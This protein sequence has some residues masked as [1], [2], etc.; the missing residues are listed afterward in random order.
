MEE[1]GNQPDLIS[2]LSDSILI[3]ILSFLPSNSSGQTC[4]LSRRWRHLWEY[5]PEL[6]LYDCADAQLFS[7]LTHRK[8][9]KLKTFHVSMRRYWLSTQYTIDQA[10]CYCST[11]GVEELYL[12][13]CY[14]IDL[15]LRAKT[16][17]C[18]Q[19]SLRVLQLD[20]CFV[21]CPNRINL[22]KVV[23]LRLSSVCMKCGAFD[24][25]ITGC[26]FVESFEIS[27]CEQVSL[28]TFDLP[29]LK[30]LVLYLC[31]NLEHIH[32]S[33]PNLKFFKHYGPLQSLKTFVMRVKNLKEA[34]YTL[35]VYYL[36]HDDGHVQ[37]SQQ[38]FQAAAQAEHLEVECSR[39][40]DT[41]EMY[42]IFNLNLTYKNVKCLTLKVVTLELLPVVPAI[43]GLLPGLK[44]LELSLYVSPPSTPEF[45]KDHYLTSSMPEENELCMQ[46][47]DTKS[48]IDFLRYSLRR[49]DIQHFEARNTQIE[50]IKLLLQ[51]APVLDVIC[52][53]DSYG[54]IAR[55]LKSRQIFT[56]CAANKDTKFLYQNK[57]YTH[58]NVHSW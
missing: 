28:L 21:S 56:N 50:F 30:R 55:L 47:K 26:P 33:V 27:C 19:T 52:F 23:V 37:G 43:I 24:N 13:F 53:I 25:I 8:S 31:N 57:F 7:F 49:I 5:V 42:R 17:S 40:Q 38:L 14:R 36:Y 22:P 39:A 58:S 9:S 6:K 15:R 51:N 11:Q 35:C 2:G 29:N 16:L 18:W 12:S 4:I 20:G 54:G 1:I 41:F 45:R 32:V 3:H 10:L 46:L 34:E 48:R 44:N